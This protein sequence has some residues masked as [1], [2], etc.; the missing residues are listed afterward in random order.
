MYWARRGYEAEL[1]VFL[2]AGKCVCVCVC[3]CGVGGGGGGGWGGKEESV[4]NVNKETLEM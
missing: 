4:N 2:G 1:A 3:V